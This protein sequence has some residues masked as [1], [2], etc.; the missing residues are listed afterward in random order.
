MC[1]R[2][3]LCSVEVATEPFFISDRI[4]QQLILFIVHGGFVLCASLI[5]LTVLRLYCS[6]R[7]WYLMKKGLGFLGF[8]MYFCG[9]ALFMRFRM[10]WSGFARSLSI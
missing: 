7:F 3:T 6:R 4:L 1:S 2:N 8:R 5:M 9:S 10:V